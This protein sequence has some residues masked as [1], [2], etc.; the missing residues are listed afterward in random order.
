MSQISQLS[1]LTI[2]VA[3]CITTGVPHT[4]FPV[5]QQPNVPLVDTFM[6]KAGFYHFFVKHFWNN[7]LTVSLQY[8]QNVTLHTIEP[9][10]SHVECLRSFWS[11]HTDRQRFLAFIERYVSGISMRS[12]W[13]MKTIQIDGI[14]WRTRREHRFYY[15]WALIPASVSMSTNHYL[16]GGPLR[17]LQAGNEADQGCITTGAG[18]IK[19][20]TEWTV[21]G[22]SH[23]YFSGKALLLPK[24]L[25]RKK[26]QLQC[27]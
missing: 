1:K 24:S 13:I 27:R 3:V 14:R 5:P 21:N 25:W 9:S 17:S 18:G 12:Q 11:W 16:L 2:S 23:H 15:R 8:K 7:L 26:R 22:G 4:T 19:C 10:R 6:T 20:N